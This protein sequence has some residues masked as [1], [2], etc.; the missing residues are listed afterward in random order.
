MYS[1]LCLSI[2]YTFE[3]TLKHKDLWFMLLTE[4]LCI[5]LTVCLTLYWIINDFNAFCKKLLH[6]SALNLHS[7]IE[8]TFSNIL[9]SFWNID[10]SFRMYDPRIWGSPTD[11]RDRTRWLW[12][13]IS[14]IINYV[15]EIL[16]RNHHFLCQIRIQW[17]PFAKKVVSASKRAEIVRNWLLRNTYKLPRNQL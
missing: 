13:P 15:I 1:S 9:R 4:S 16:T 8:R 5:W 17:S 12:H 7:I 10:S 6:P 2:F 11:D 3:E 14:K